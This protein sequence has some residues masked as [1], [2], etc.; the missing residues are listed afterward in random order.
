MSSSYF[1]TYGGNRVTFG[2][3][4]GPVAWE[5]V[6][7][8]VRRYEYTLWKSP[9]GEGRNSGTMVSAFSSFDEVVVGY[10][11]SNGSYATH[12]IEY[13]TYKPGSTYFLERTMSNDSTYY[14]FGTL[15]S[16]NSTSWKCPTDGDFNSASAYRWIQTNTA[17]TGAWQISNNRGRYSAVCEIIGVKYR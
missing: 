5:Y 13:K 1:V 14:M 15:L 2:G 8:P 11:W 10:G 12:G 17:N 7:P 9:D 6:P 16:S 3:T 4:P